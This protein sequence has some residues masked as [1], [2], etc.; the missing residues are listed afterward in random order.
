M[1]IPKLRADARAIWDAAVAAAKPDGGI[2]RALMGAELSRAIAA[3]RRILVV[4]GGKAGAAMAAA[5]ERE[6]VNRLAEISGIVNIP[7]GT[8]LP[9][10][11]IKLNVA[12]PAGSNEP[13]AAGVEGALQ[14]LQL[15]AAAEPSDIVIALISGGGSALLPAPVDGVSLE[16]KQVV[17]RLLHRSGATIVEMNCV[18]K[19]LSQI[20]GGG[21]AAIARC[22]VHSL[23]ISDVVGDPF[24]VIASGPTAPDLTTFADAV[25]VLRKFRLLDFLPLSVCTHL[26]AGAAG[27]KNETPKSLPP[28]VRNRV[29][30][31][32]RDAIAAA[33]R[34][35][36]ALSY[37]VIN[38]GSAVEGETTEVAKMAA[39]SMRE[40]AGKAGC[41]LIGGETTVTLPPNHGKGGRNTEFVLAALLALQSSGLRNYVVLSGGTDGEDG[42]TDAAGAIGDETTLPRAHELGLTPADFLYRHDSYIFFDATNDLLRT[43]LT[44]TNVMDIRVLLIGRQ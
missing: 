33:S 12:R 3:A 44:Q 30:G 22:P 14:M 6:L 10:S 32:N 25:S 42:P 40:M 21:L 24:D 20:K 8:E 16:D 4:G 37:E 9:L 39:E 29:I 11:A 17:T 31:N 5:V 28:S 23:I 15:V 13:T 26:L 2:H 36:E 41:L 1:A 27:Q 34:C 18:R 7:A 19:H 35:A 43:G 38:L